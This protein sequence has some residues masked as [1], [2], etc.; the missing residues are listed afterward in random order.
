MAKL[1]V[2]KSGYV[3]YSNPCHLPGGS[4]AG[5]QFCGPGAKSGAHKVDYKGPFRKVVEKQKS[6]ME[7]VVGG[8]KDGRVSSHEDVISIGK[9]WVKDNQ[10]LFDAFNAS[11]A[12]YKRNEICEEIIGK[13]KEGKQGDKIQIEKDVGF[14]NVKSD[15]TKK[16]LTSQLQEVRQLTGTNVETL[17]YVEVRKG[18]RAYAKKEDRVIVLGGSFK[19]TV[20]HEAGHHIEFS[21]MRVKS[22]AT[23]FRKSR[24]IGD[25]SPEPLSNIIKGYKSKDER[26]YNTNLICKYAGKVYRDGSTEI[27]SV[28]M[29]HFAS[30]AKLGSLIKKDPGYFHFMIG[31]LQGQKAGVI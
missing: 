3:D 11:N 12:Q 16:T 4:P 20:F 27:I 1:S 30:G 17:Q 18:V 15:T 19:P 14:I 13:L 22:L 6:A 29:E 31:I 23:Q 2:F 7:E 8:L 24:T 5:G 9:A 28:G 10:E 25:Q 21:N 26:G